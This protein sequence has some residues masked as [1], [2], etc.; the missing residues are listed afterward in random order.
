[1][2]RLLSIAAATV[3]DLSP[4]DT[5][6]VAGQAGFDGAGI[7]FDPAT[8][9]DATTNEVRRRL[10]DSGVVALDVEPVILGADGDPGDALIDA[11]IGLGAR[12]VLVA[13]RHP[14]H[15]ATI[16]RFAQLCDRAAPGGITCVLEFL[17]IF[18]VN[19][20][21]AAA[22]IVTAAGRPNG[23]I[24]V[25]SL[26][27]ARSGG[28]VTDVAD[29]MAASSDLFPYLQIADAPADAPADLY[30]EALHG[31]LLP[32]DGALPL[33]ELLDAV[34]DVPLS[35]ELRSASVREAYPDPLERSAAVLAATRRLVA[36]A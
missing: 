9:T 17:P 23:A 6:T 12:N 5:V 33:H 8:W 28:T 10:D 25:D 22:S 4:A 15:A 2:D 26:H 7:W 29:L 35:L 32:G 31:R 1:M 21:A 19:D 16:E 24:L 14:D 27:L 13:S 34:P 36:D 20:L 11:A 18:V 3:A 30:H